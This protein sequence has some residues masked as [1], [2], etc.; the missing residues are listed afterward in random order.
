MNFEF[1]SQTDTGRVRTNNEDS[2]ALDESCAV[3]VLADGMGGYAAGE[4][5]SGMVTTLLASNFERFLPTCSEENLRQAGGAEAYLR[6]EVCAANAAVFNASQS[7]PQYAGMGTTLVVAWFSG[8]LMHVAHVGDSRLYRFRDDHLEQLTRDH[9][10]LQEQLDGGMI[11]EEEARFSVHKNLL[12]RAI[13]VEAEV[14]VEI[15]VHELRAGDIFLLCSD[16]LTDMLDEVEILEVL[17]AAGGNLNVA[18]EQLVEEANANGGRDNISV[19]LI[20]VPAGAI[21]DEVWWRK[22]LA[23]WK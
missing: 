17:L 8:K 22:L 10:L 12:T 4:V 5:A 20:E 1:Y 21:S 3:A 11:S 16:G 2:V 6:D 7:Q 18:A 9:S 15:G 14:D 23:M 19:I 13:G